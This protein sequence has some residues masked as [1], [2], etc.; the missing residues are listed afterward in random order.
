MKTI[1]NRPYNEIS[2]GDHCERTHTI[3][4]QDLL[5]FAAVSGD[6]NPVHLDADY[7]ATTRFKGQI[8]H[9]MFTGAL[10]SAALAMELPGPGTVYLGQNIS[11]RRPVKIGDTLTVTLTVT[12]KH[13]SKSIVTIACDVK[14]QNGKTV[15]DGEA[16]VMAPDSKMTVEVPDLPEVTVSR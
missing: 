5:L 13:D 12:A 4:G 14:N 16:T 11:F 3:S 2:I 9:G 1:S 10:I 6:M 15:A 8:A 7:A